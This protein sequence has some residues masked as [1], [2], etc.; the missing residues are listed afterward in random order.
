V[1][2]KPTSGLNFD[3]SMQDSSRH[4]RYLKFR[5]VRLIANQFSLTGLGLPAAWRRGIWPVTLWHGRCR[6]DSAAMSEAASFGSRLPS[7]ASRPGWLESD[8]ITDANSVGVHSPTQQSP[9]QWEEIQSSA[10][11]FPLQRCHGY[12]EL[13]ACE[14]VAVTVPDQCEAHSD[15][16][17]IR[18]DVASTV[19]FADHDTG[20]E[21]PSQVEKELVAVAS[22]PPVDTSNLMTGDVVAAV[23][24]H[25]LCAVF[26]QCTLQVI[27][28]MVWP[29]SP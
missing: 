16:V 17:G 11:D 5:S 10:Q 19:R 8:E 25:P 7:G 29:C 22:L 24:Q 1:F 28:N 6:I 4:A 3:F 2:E 9:C 26:K 20:V 13:E 12:V 21:L 14:S 23:L 27:L 18:A 15:A